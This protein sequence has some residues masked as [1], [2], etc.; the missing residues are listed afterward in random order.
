M[1]F[2]K[3]PLIV[4]IEKTGKI[5]DKGGTFRALLTDVSKAFDCMTHDL[6]IAKLYALNFD[7]NRLNFIFD[8]LTGKRKRVKINFSLSSYLD[9][10]QGVLQKS[11]LQ[12]LFDLFL[13]NIVLFAEEAG[14]RRYA[15]DK[16][17]YV[18]SEKGK[19]EEVGK[20]GFE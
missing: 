9:L 5:L 8:H 16:T 4:T 10:L 19:L 13:C 1:V 11:I 17:R 6:F 7:M 14:I 3:Y 15:D 12:L 18:C 20:T 2:T